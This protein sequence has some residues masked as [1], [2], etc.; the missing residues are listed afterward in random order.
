M[1]SCYDYA[2]AYFKPLGN[3][4]YPT[5][6]GVLTTTGNC[7]DISIK[8]NTNR[9]VR[10]CF[11]R[12]GCQGSYTLATAGSWNVIAFYVAD[13]TDFWFDFRSDAQSTGS[14]AA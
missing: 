5:G 10:V 14:W 12:S 11:M 8:P 3:Y 4:A 2:Q 7:G 13:N 6:S 9:Y 1:Q